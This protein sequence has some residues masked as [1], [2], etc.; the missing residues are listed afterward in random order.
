MGAAS[1]LPF[2]WQPQEGS[3]TN[4][5]E[6]GQA[7]TSPVFA[8]L[9]IIFVASSAKLSL[10]SSYLFPYTAIATT[11]ALGVK[12]SSLTLSP[13]RGNDRLA[14]GSNWTTYLLGALKGQRGRSGLRGSLLWWL[15]TYMPCTIQFNIDLLLLTVSLSQAVQWLTSQSGNIPPFGF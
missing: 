11:Q 4:G 8:L 2:A 5:W 1:R 6:A 13:W 9:Q 7:A 10:S 12:R 3:Q 15:G 14:I